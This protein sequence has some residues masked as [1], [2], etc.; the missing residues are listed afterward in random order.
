MLQMTSLRCVFV[1]VLLACTWGCGKGP[2]P[3]SEQNSANQNAQTPTQAQPAATPTAQAPVQAAAPDQAPVYN[4][5]VAP[6]PSPAQV[7]PVQ[8]A[9][10][11]DGSKVCAQLTQAYR[12][13]A[14]EQRHL[15]GSIGELVAGGYVAG[16]PEPPPGTQYAIDKS[17]GAVV[18]TKR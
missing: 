16:L 1:S 17:Q 13:F 18:L 5:R 6:P 7:K 3:V 15:P 4:P 14:V 11:A 9:V 8:V 10:G 12:K 2:A